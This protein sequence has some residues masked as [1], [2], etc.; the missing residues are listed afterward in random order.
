MAIFLNLDSRRLPRSIISS[1]TVHASWRPP[2]GPPCRRSSWISRSANPTNAGNVNRYLSAEVLYFVLLMLPPWL[3]WDQPL[4]IVAQR[5]RKLN[6]VT[7]EAEVLSSRLLLR[8]D[9]KWQKNLVPVQESKIYSGSNILDCSDQM[10]M[11]HL[12]ELGT[13]FV[14]YLFFLL[15]AALTCV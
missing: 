6:I 13:T 2:P 4:L 5:N 9:C 15:A 11:Q 8:S 1:C 7:T 14:L 3:Y 12:L 10:Q